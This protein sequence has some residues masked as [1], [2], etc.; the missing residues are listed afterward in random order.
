[1]GKWS[2]N[3]L[4]FGRLPKVLDITGTEIARRCGLRQQVLSRYTTNENVVSVQVLIKL[5]NALRMPARFFVVDN[6]NFVIPNREM[7]TIPIDSWHPITWDSQAVERTFGDG[8]GRIFWKDVAVAMGVS[9]QKPH[10]RFSLRRRFRIDDFINICNHYTLS[11]F[12][13]LIDPNSPDNSRKNRFLTMPSGKE[14]TPPFSP[15]SVA[16]LQQRITALERSVA[17][18]TDKFAALQQQ[19]TDL[20]ARHDRLEHS[21]YVSINNVTNSHI[22]LNAHHV[23]HDRVDINLDKR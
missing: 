22:G 23:E 13:F 4:L 16:A 21:V 10:E 5:C 11:P 15:T 18:L 12:L 1:M 19:H 9:S 20:L 17:E 8:E 14:A 2:F 6:K 7:A 3:T